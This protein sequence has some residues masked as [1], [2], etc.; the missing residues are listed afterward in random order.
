MLSVLFRDTVLYY[1]LNII[2][3]KLYLCDRS[4]NILFLPFSAVKPRYP[5]SYFLPLY[6]EV[7]LFTSLHL[8][9]LQRAFVM[10]FHSLNLQSF[11]E[12]HTLYSFYSHYYNNSSL[13]LHVPYM[14]LAGHPRITATSEMLSNKKMAFLPQLYGV[15]NDIQYM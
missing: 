13:S 8:A 6:S 10:C 4:F 5:F 3:I 12:P 11:Q 15:I 7:T 1:I 2:I 14:C 9:G